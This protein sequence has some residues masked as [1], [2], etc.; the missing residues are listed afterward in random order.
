ML[1]RSSSSLFKSINHITLITSKY[2]LGVTKLTMRKQNT[3]AHSF[4]L[5]QNT[6]QHSLTFDKGMPKGI[7]PTSYVES[8]N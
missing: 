1:P 6:G 5:R 7:V 3:D 4:L 2:K 8:R